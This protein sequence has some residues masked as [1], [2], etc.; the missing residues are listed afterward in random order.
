MLEFRCGRKKNVAPPGRHRRSVAG[1][2]YLSLAMTGA[3]P[4]PGGPF[5]LPSSSSLSLS[6]S[7]SASGGALQFKCT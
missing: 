3:V 7:A 5:F 6:V 1:V 4:L 2:D